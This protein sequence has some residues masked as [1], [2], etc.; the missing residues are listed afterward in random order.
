[1]QMI[2]Y[3][4]NRIEKNYGWRTDGECQ[5]CQDLNSTT[6]KEAMSHDS[7]YITLS[8]LEQKEYK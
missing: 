2:I 8:N 3:L 5:Q 4:Q 1:M 7:L 6:G